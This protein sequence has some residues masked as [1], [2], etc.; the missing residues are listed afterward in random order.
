MYKA[1][2]ALLALP[3]FVKR[4]TEIQGTVQDPSPH[5]QHIQEY[6]LFLSCPCS[7]DLFCFSLSQGK[8]WIL[9][10]ALHS[11]HSTSIE[12][13]GCSGGGPTVLKMNNLT[14]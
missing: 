13:F 6:A 8:G 9:T 12:H 7:G 5:L 14:F 4:P 2:R 1:Q 10:A 11:P 3:V